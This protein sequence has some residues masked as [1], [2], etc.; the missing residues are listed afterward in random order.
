M[1]TVTKSRKILNG[2]VVSAAM[3]KTIVVSIERLK[4]HP[5]YGKYIKNN[6]KYKVHDEAN[7]CN[8]NDKV[9][10]I[11]CRPLSKDKNWRVKEILERAK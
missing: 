7:D 9:S 8:E 10:I 11:E 4:K 2:T 3:D 5:R 6:V 1:S